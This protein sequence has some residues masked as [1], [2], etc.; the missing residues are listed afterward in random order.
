LSEG[1]GGGAAPTILVSCEHG[2]HEVPAAYQ[3]LFAG[4]EEA[5]ASHR[6]WDEGALPLARAVARSW[7]APLHAATVSRLV[8]DLNRSPHHPTVFSEWTRALTREERG[9]LLG[10]WHEPHRRRLDEEVDRA[11]N[12]GG[13]VLHVGVH[14]FTPVLNGSVRAAD[15]ALLYDPARRAERA[16]CATWIGAI[17]EELPG[18]AVRRNQP[19]RGASDGLTTWLRGRHGARYLGIELEVNQRLLGASGRFPAR[20]AAAVAEGLCAALG[21]NGA[22]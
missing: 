10:A 5:L 14:T 15:V 21:T 8:V 11:G 4:A 17:A 3:A 20:I 2:G 13:V 7:G 12:G 16:L 1:G 22:G 18:L 6:G 19:Y 9:A